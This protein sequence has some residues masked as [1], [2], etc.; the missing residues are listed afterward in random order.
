[1]SDLAEQIEADALEAQRFSRKHLVLELDFSETSIDE[2]EKN[3]DTVE[4]AIRGGK[5]DENVQILTRIWGAYLGEALRKQ[6]GGEWTEE[7][8]QSTLRTANAAAQPQ[9]AVRQR[10]VE[11]GTPLG[12]YF[13]EMKEQL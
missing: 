1:M 8:G 10:L 12:D 3:I 2:L 4:Y 11:G 9:E 5:S 6:C 7:D 13:R